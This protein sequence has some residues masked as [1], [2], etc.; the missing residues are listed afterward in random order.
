VILTPIKK[1]YLQMHICIFLWGFTGILG[2][3]IQLSEGLLVWYRMVL[4]AA[5]LLI[6][7]LFRKELRLPPAKELL[8]LS[9]V[10][11]VIMLHWVTFYGAIKYSNVSIA[12]SCFSSSA[13]FT[14]LLSPLFERRKLIV[15]EILFGILAIIGI[16]LIFSF[17]Q[18][19]AIG[20]ILAI[21]SAALSALF[22][23]MNKKMVEKHQPEMIT[24]VE[25]S[26]GLVY[27]TMLL[28]IYLYYFPAPSLLPS[29]MD[30]LWL[31]I[32]SFF[33][34]TIPFTLSL[35][36]LKK[37]SAFTLN[38]SVNLEPIYS[39]ILAI[40]IFQENKELTWGFYLGT[41]IILSS[42]VLHGLYK[43]R[44]KRKSA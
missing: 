32:L 9:G 11:F 13:L 8:R 20:I 18:L 12:L 40:A 14:A 42:V 36:A 37:V 24:F 10:G 25:L 21:V 44:Q 28:P 31:L 27:L 15:T 17:Q 19:Y 33:C 5:T 38:L 4:T 23:I 7:L 16:Y 26:S 22:T 35:K 1:A 29:N 39:I 30:W 41:A 43:F 6:I 2:K 3:L 34:T